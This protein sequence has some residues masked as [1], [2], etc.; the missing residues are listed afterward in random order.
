MFKKNLLILDDDARICSLL[1]QG[2]A[3]EFNVKTTQDIEKAYHIATKEHSDIL[4]LDIHLKTGN[5]LELCEKLRKNQITKKIPILIFTGQ[6]S[7]EKMLA[8]FD[9][10]A[11]DYIEKPVDLVVLKNR[12]NARIARSKDMGNENSNFENLK[13]FPERLE[14]ELNGKLIRLSE[15]EFDLL[16]I[17]LTNPNKNISR[18]E[19]L[20]TIWKDTQVSERS[21][22]V[23]ISS[24]RKKLDDFNYAI[25]SLYGSGYIL[26][27][28][29]ETSG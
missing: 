25:K 20:N 17:F 5:G 24:L 2:L 28:I 7:K 27:K 19:I 26:K 8:S 3:D 23:H 14:I 9:L 1:E 18:E 29:K 10:G 21:V 12:L 4:L 6:G 11:D 16:R 13:V 22:D 15:I